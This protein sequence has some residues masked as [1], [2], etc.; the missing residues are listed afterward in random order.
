MTSMRKSGSSCVKAGQCSAN[1]LRILQVKAPTDGAGQTGGGGGLAVALGEVLAPCPSGPR[2][3]PA[4]RSQAVKM[5]RLGPQ[6]SPVL[7]VCCF[8]MLQIPASGKGT[9]TR[10][11]LASRNTET[12]LDPSGH[13]GRESSF[14][15][16]PP[17]YPSFCPPAFWL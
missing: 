5:T 1:G 7:A 2:L 10:P 11:Y 6:F 15:P 4:G 16:P 17:T 12:D 8:C 14:I 13:S 3:W 9:V